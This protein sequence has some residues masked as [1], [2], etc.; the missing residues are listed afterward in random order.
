LNTPQQITIWDL[1]EF[2]NKFLDS[3]LSSSEIMAR[4]F[5]N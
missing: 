3:S 5:I 1:E 2:F 4:F